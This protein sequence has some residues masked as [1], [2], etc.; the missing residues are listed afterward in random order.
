MYYIYI[1]RCEG[2]LL[3]TGITADIRRRLDEH[4]S[5]SRKCAKFTR[6]HKAESLAALW[7]APDRST[8]SKL[9]YRIKQLGREQKLLFISS[10]EKALTL[11]G[12]DCGISLARDEFEDLSG[13][14]P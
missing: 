7:K 5:C 2:G 1:L 6:S 13:S 11:L 4:F 3:Y 9:E 10:P 12:E 14:T 8:A